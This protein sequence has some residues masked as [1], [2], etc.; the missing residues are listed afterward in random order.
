MLGWDPIFEY[1]GLTYAEM[2]KAAKVCSLTVADPQMR[3]NPLTRLAEQ[4][5]ASLQ[6]P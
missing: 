2:D 4:D 1:E 5:L 3:M 6:G